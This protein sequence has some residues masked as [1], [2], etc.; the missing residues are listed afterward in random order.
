MNKTFKRIISMI[1]TVC[2]LFLA[3]V[4]VFAADEE[5]YLSD[6]RLI[7]AADF[8]EATEILEDSDLEG[9]KLFNA[10]LNEN[11]D[12]TGVYL[13]YKTTTDIEDAITDIAIMQMNG[14]YNEGNYQEMIKQSLAEYEKMGQNYLTAIEYFNKGVD[15][16]HYLSDVAFR[17][18]NFYNVVTEGIDDVP[19]FEGKRLGDIF[20]EG[21]D[22]A[23]LA[24]MF[25]EGNV[26][27]LDNIRSLIAM[28]VSYNENGKTYLENVG[29][30]A[31]K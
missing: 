31:A 18:L 23:D 25:M 3:T 8:N 20:A 11:T 13:A 30:E 19:E 14:G 12:K 24:T 27:A 16:G 22:V 6:L 21:I 15:A 10:N 5:E 1:L 2:M 29:D 7:Y 17:Q 26:Y 9:Y 28:G 4:P